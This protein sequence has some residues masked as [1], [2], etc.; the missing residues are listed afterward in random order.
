MKLA[1][2]IIVG[3]LMVLGVPDAALAQ[4]QRVT[5]Q[6]RSRAVAFVNVNVIPMDRERVESGQTV[7]IQSGRKAGWSPPARQSLYGSPRESLEDIGWLSLSFDG[8]FR[9]D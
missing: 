5:S 2:R 6:E 1:V 4:Q 8:A 3:G 7:V 9:A